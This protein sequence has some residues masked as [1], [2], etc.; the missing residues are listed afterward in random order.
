MFPISTALYLGVEKHPD[1]S[2]P[3]GVRVEEVRYTI[4]YRVEQP[5]L[6]NWLQDWLWKVGDHGRIQERLLMAVA[7][8]EARLKGTRAHSVWIG[9]GDGIRVLIRL[10]ELLRA[11]IIDCLPTREP[12]PFERPGD[13]SPG[14]VRA[15]GGKTDLFAPI[16]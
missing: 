10:P 3:E 15:P 9:I 13:D 16:C 5:T 8:L 12:D 2:G 6:Y 14:F 7:A 11:A 4:F 1:A